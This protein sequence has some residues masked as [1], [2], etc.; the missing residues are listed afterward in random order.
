MTNPY[1]LSPEEHEATYQRIEA[2]RLPESEPRDNPRAIITGGQPGSGKS[3]ITSRAARELEKEGGHILIDADDLREES[4]LYEAAM[5]DDDRLAANRTHPDA[6]GWATKLMA[7]AVESRRNVLIDQTSKDPAAVERLAGRLKGAGYS[8]ELR[9]MAVNEKISE[10]RIQT[11]YESQKEAYGV[12]RFS[13]KDNHDIA[14][15]G[16]AKTVA[17]VELSKSVDALRVYDKDHVPI[18]E[19]VL[20]GGDWVDP[21]NAAELM[22]AE[23]NRP[24]TLEERREVASQY[25]QLAVMIEAPARAARPEEKEVISILRTEAHES[26]DSVSRK[27]IEFEEIDRTH[28]NEVPGMDSIMRQGTLIEAELRHQDFSSRNLPAEQIKEIA[29]KDIEDFAY[30]QGKPEQRQ[31]VVL[32][33]GMMA[34]EHYASHIKDFAPPELEPA[35]EAANIYDQQLTNEITLPDDRDK[36]MEL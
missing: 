7:A 16:V 27:L 19:N 34:N 32:V 6:G 13:T 12:G 25:D 20:Q 14:F 15:A 35:V 9:V 8:V 18:K 2:E 17:S 3:G 24:L 5:L 29:I 28:Q 11:R 21:A 36:G 26:F 4:R 30:L 22:H 10:Q 31:L 23:R 1:Q 33:G